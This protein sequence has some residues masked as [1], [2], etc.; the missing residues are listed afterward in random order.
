MERYWEILS[1]VFTLIPTYSNQISKEDIPNT[2]GVYKGI[3]EKACNRIM[4]QLLKIIYDLKYRSYVP[5]VETQ[6]KNESAYWDYRKINNIHIY[7][8][9]TRLFIHNHSDRP[10]QRYNEI[11]KMIIIKDYKRA[12]R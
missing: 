10:M 9:N 2:N 1:K 12:D 7:L 11:S 4:S 5:G 8:I 3:G 6:V